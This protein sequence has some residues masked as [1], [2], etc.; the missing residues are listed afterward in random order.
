MAS[1]DRNSIQCHHQT[2]PSY[3]CV[4]DDVSEDWSGARVEPKWLFTDNETNFSRV[5]GSE[6]HSKFVKDAF[7]RFI[8][9]GTVHTV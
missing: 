4:V 6:N 8:I 2:L 3:T 7:H 1:I 9:E 5:F